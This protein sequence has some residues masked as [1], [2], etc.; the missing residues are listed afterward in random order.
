MPDYTTLSKDS[1]ELMKK[2]CETFVTDLKNLKS[3]KGDKKAISSLETSLDLKYKNIGAR[4][5]QDMKI[6]AEGEKTM[7]LHIEGQLR[8]ASTFYTTGKA[9]LKTF[10][11]KRGE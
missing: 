6:A 2:N 5:L 11:E 8:S 7:A 3:S 1:I 4:Y 9:T 10:K